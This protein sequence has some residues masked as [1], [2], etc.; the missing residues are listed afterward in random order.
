MCVQGKTPKC[1]NRCYSRTGT[2][3]ALIRS[4]KLTSCNILPLQLSGVSLT[5]FCTLSFTALFTFLVFPFELCSGDGLTDEWSLRVSIWLA[6]LRQSSVRLA[7]LQLPPLLQP[8][9]R[10]RTWRYQ[11]ETMLYCETGEGLHWNDQSP[12]LPHKSLLS[13]FRCHRQSADDKHFT[14]ILLLNLIT[15]KRPR[16][17]FQSRDQR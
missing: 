5:W 8:E 4:C 2:E 14:Y 11:N 7:L 15:R 16:T 12:S 17:A 6:L 3:K 10:N 1:P 13:P 9:S